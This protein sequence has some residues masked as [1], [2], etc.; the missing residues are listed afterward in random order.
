MILVRMIL[1]SLLA[2]C[3]SACGSF[4]YDGTPPGQLKGQLLVIWV[5]ED[6]FVYWPRTN[7]PL[8]FTLGPDLQQKL[9]VQ[10]IR[11]GLMY[12]DGGSIPRPLRALDGFSPWGYAPAY[13]LHD[14]A[15][16]AHYCNVADVPHDAR[17]ATEYEKISR[18][19]FEDSAALLAE[20]MKTLMIDDRVRTNSEAF[21]LI[22]SGVDS[23]VAR[24]LW[25][26]TAAGLCGQVT[27]PD[28]AMIENALKQKSLRGFLTGS[29]ASRTPPL[30][31]H[32][33]AF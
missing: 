33:Q 7:D 11:P 8:T 2:L 31:V 23:V 12:T 18:F 3:V 15:F 32:S 30:I 17:D 13:I 10:T 16:H 24:N 14:W 20:V 28:Q 27:A 1:A 22:S 9:G 5:G 29:R 25:N 26:S 19:E 4:T 21:N 6:R